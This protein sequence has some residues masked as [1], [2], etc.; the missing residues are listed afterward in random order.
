LGTYESD[1]NKAYIE[2]KYLSTAFYS[3]QVPFNL[4]LEDWELATGVSYDNG[5]DVWSASGFWTCL[6]VSAYQGGRFEDNDPDGLSGPP[7]A[8]PGIAWGATCQDNDNACVIYLE[9]INNETSAIWSEEQFVAHEIG[10]TSGLSDQEPG[11]GSC[12]MNLNSADPTS[13]CK[14]CKAHF[15]KYQ[16]WLATH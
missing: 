3:D 14:N 9:V 11:T 6:V 5:Q 12:F 7:A 1:F 15:R 10:H 13:F 8:D 4:N 16:T 2:I